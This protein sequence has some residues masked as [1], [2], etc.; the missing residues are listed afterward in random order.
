M[1]TEKVLA[2]LRQHPDFLAEHAEELGVRLRD[3]KVRSFAQG[4]IAS[5]RLK[6]EKMAQRVEEMLDAAHSN[7]ATMQRLLAFDLRLLKANT[8][9]Q[10]AKAVSAS[11]KDDFG[12]PHFALKLICAPKNKA[13][14]PEGLLRPAGHAAVQE[15]LALKQPLCG[16]QISPAARKLLPQDVILESFLQLPLH[17]GGETGGVLL[18]GHEDAAHFAPGLPTEYVERLAGALAAVLARMTGWSS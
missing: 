17:F 9:G 8:V 3:D 2:F 12:L 16:H 14:L 1:Q 4:Q 15:W 10:A 11:L 13:R 5:S 6:T 7:H 18:L